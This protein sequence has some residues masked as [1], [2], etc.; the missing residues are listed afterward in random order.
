MEGA[1]GACARAAFA[2]KHAAPSVAFMRLLGGVTCLFNDT[3]DSFNSESACSSEHDSNERQ[4]YW[5][6]AVFLLTL[7]VRDVREGQ[8]SSNSAD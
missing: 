6:N 4:P 1:E 3:D 2:R 7:T 5:K 8:S